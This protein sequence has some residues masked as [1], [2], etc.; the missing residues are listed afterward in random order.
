M[1]EIRYEDYVNRVHG[2]WLGKLIG[3]TIGGPVEGEKN[4]MSHEYYASAPEVAAFNDDND[5]QVVWLHALEEYGLDLTSDDLAREWLEHVTYPCC[6]YGY[7]VRN[8]RLGIAPP[9]SGSFNNEYFRECMGCPIRSEIWAFICP[10][11]PEMAAEY[12]ARDAVLDHAG[13]SVLAEQFLAAVQSM[14]FLESDPGALVNQALRFVPEET[15]LGRC[16]RDVVSWCGESGDWRCVRQRIIAQY[17]SPDMTNAAQNL[18]IMAMSLLL[19]EGDFE[20]TLLIAANSG[21][22]T[23]CTA[24]SVGATLG[25]LVGPEGI[26]DRWRVPMGDEFGVS[27]E[28]FGL[29][30]ERMGI[31]EFADELCRIGLA[32]AERRGRVRITGGPAPRVLP[33]PPLP[34]ARLT[35][36]YPDGPAAVLGCTKRIVVRVADTAPGEP[37]GEVSLVPPAGWDVTCDSHDLHSGASESVFAVKAPVLL[38]K[39]PQRNIF[40]AKWKSASG[41][42]VSREFGIAGGTHW[43]A[44]G[45]FFHTG[46]IFQDSCGFEEDW[47]GEK[48]PFSDILADLSKAGTCEAKPVAFESDHL[49]LN[50]V[51][52]RQGPSC[53]YLLGRFESPEEQRVHLQI[54]TLDGLALW[55][56]GGLLVHDHEHRSPLPWTHVAEAFLR[57]GTNDL[58]LK[59]ATCTGAYD[60]WFAFREF[61]K[62]KAKLEEWLRNKGDVWPYS[63]HR[64]HYVTN[65]VSVLLHVP[66]RMSDTEV[67]RCAASVT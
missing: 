44:V 21:Y 8:W 41:Q 35:I 57:K 62:D 22:D 40:T 64:E 4:L 2:A 5:F 31:R 55:L 65:M 54:G 15:R 33:T 39:L 36:E 14:L 18:G 29:P 16:L 37:S 25:G 43:L 47:I 3:G 13:D 51:F 27:S 63:W 56:N 61:K 52:S 50:A 60:V 10:G 38:G 45:P 49:D 30:R 24:G 32:V 66:P 11:D 12:A 28:V 26:P 19:G 1:R 42:L 59:F 7:A 48:R 23:D 67:G 46:N 20:R 17:S 9:L 6:E 53:I 34:S 58:L